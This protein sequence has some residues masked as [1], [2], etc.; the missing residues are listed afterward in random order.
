MS[1]IAFLHSAQ[2]CSDGYD[3]RGQKS[4][5]LLGFVLP[6]I[7]DGFIYLPVG[8][9]ISATVITLKYIRHAFIRDNCVLDF[10]H[11]CISS[12]MIKSLIL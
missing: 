9:V 8:S 3:W 12:M 2:H 1:L 5:D 7:A 4:F 6:V 10:V 11:L